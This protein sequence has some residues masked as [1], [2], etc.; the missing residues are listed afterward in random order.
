MR[1][2]AILY[3]IQNEGLMRAILLDFALH[4]LWTLLEWRLNIDGLLGEDCSS[5]RFEE[6]RTPAMTYRPG[7]RREAGEVA[8]T[9]SML[10]VC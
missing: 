7:T 3:E 4:K 8:M 6:V 5:H 9:C 1:R 10:Q 2:F